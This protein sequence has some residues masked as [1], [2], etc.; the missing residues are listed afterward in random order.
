MAEKIRCIIICGSPDFDANFIKSFVNPETDFII[1][2][3]SGYL[4][5][6]RSDIIPHLFVGDFDSF[7]GEIPDDIEVIKLKVHK[8][9]TD[10]MHCAE[11]AAQRNFREVVLLGAT[12]ARLDH[13]LA[14]LSVL[15]YLSD[16]KINAYI[17]N[18]KETVK[19]LSIGEYI[20]NNQNEKTFSVFPFG[21]DKITISYDGE[22]EYP[23]NNLTVK[24][25]VAVGISNIFRCDSVKVRLSKGKALFIV[26][27]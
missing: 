14:N 26:N 16:N 24:S 12:G 10:S 20:F 2:A 9:D 15:E 18:E 1:C 4:T 23:A 21:C 3:D 7:S 11:I 5:A 27:K 22:V 8:D 6:K 19:L 25:S 17:E 13:T